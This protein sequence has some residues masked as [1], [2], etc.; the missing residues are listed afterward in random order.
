V[1][2]LDLTV[3]FEHSGLQGLGVRLSA[4]GLEILQ[5]GPPGQ[6]YHNTH[7]QEVTTDFLQKIN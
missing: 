3:E 4:D 5:A 7:G 2:L 6:Q 1:A